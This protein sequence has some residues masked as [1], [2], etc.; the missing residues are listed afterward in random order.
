MSPHDDRDRDE[1]LPIQPDDDD[2]AELEPHQRR[3]EE[4]ASVYFEGCRRLARGIRTFKEWMEERNE[5]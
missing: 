1:T 5:R 3:I 2:I 4:I